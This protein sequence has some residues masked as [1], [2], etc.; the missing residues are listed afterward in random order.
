MLAD[1]SACCLWDSTQR[2]DSPPSAY[3]DVCDELIG[4]PFC[5]AGDRGLSLL[6]EIPAR[7]DGRHT[8]LSV[9][10]KGFVRLPAAVMLAGA[11]QCSELDHIEG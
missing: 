10:T 8:R 3:T 11:L 1:G 4:Q 6:Q 5:Q 7:E 2:T 9:A